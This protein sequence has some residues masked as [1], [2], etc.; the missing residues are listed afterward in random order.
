MWKAKQQLSAAGY[1]NNIGCFPMARAISAKTCKISNI[2]QKFLDIFLSNLTGK[3]T[4]AMATF[5][6]NS[7]SVWQTKQIRN[8]RTRK[9]N[10]WKP[11]SDFPNIFDIPETFP[12]S[13]SA[14]PPPRRN[15]RDLERREKL[16]KFI[17]QEKLRKLKKVLTDLK[18][19]RKL[20][21]NFKAQ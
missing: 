21:K 3:I 19:Q 1:I 2:L 13:A 6:V 18:L 11:V 15:T 16:M 5:E 8:K 17:K 9:G 7:V 14:K 4:L 10:S 20:K 12:P